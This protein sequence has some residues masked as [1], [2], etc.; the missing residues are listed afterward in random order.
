MA[1]PCSCS[2][3]SVSR[4]SIPHRLMS[5]SIATMTQSEPV[6]LL[7]ETITTPL[8]YDDDSFLSEALVTCGKS[9]HLFRA[10][11]VDWRSGSVTR[12]TDHAAMSGGP[13]TAIHSR[14]DFCNTNKYA[15]WVDLQD[16]LAAAR[17]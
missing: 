3:F 9:P 4:L 2:K 16:S 7:V 6:P 10:P 1:T 11:S 17:V 15:L 13:P 5:T 12:M 8:V 14:E